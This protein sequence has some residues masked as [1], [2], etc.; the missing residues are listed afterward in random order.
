MAENKHWMENYSM[1]LHL[2]VTFY[3]EQWHFR[4]FFAKPYVFT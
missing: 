4:L 2:Y 1:K 3:V